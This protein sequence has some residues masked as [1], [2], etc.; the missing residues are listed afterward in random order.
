MKVQRDQAV[1]INISEVY[2]LSS[3]I[4]SLIDFVCVKHDF[5]V[6]HMHYLC[7]GNR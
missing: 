6:M 5:S 1:D 4:E 2:M 3:V 7:A